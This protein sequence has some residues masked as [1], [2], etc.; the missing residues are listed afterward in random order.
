MYRIQTMNAISEHGIEA[1]TSRGCAVGAELK[2][3]DAL[4]SIISM[5]RR[6]SV[7]VTFLGGVL[8]LKE[9]HVRDKA[10]VLVLMLVG[11]ALL[12]SGSA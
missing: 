9:G 8:I 6:T 7:V 10:H 3:P 12:L 4:L 5:I 11:V 1:L 2:E